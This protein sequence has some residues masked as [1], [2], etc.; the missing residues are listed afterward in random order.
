S[1]RRLAFD[2]TVLAE[3]AVSLTVPALDSVGEPLDAD[4]ATPDDPRREVVRVEVSGARATSHVFVEDKEL[5]L[6]DAVL[7]VE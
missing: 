5:A 7:R 1:I 6:Q 2:G 4:V 3:Q